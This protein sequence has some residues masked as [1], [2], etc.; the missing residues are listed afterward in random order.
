MRNRK[1]VTGRGERLAAGLRF[2]TRTRELQK[3]SGFSGLSRKI[4]L[5]NAVPLKY[6]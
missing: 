3:S 4:L 2:C 1:I 6:L 5:P